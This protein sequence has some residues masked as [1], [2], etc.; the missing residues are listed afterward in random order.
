M[1]SAVLPGAEENDSSFELASRLVHELGQQLNVR[2]SL[3]VYS[4]LVLDAEV[5]WYLTSN[6]CVSMIS[7][8]NLRERSDLHLYRSRFDSDLQ[9]ALGALPPT[10]G[11]CRNLTFDEATERLGRPILARSRYRL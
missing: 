4:V 8:T 11:S 5:L 6:T 7:V 9:Q 1:V 10:F 3:V 2:M